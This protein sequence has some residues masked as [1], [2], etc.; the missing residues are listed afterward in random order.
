MA[1]KATTKVPEGMYTVTPQLC[2]NGNCREAIEFYKKA[3]NAELIGNIAES[4]D[5]KSVWHAMIK[6]GN[7]HIMMGDAMPGGYETG[8]KGTSTVGI[9][10]Y[11]EDCDAWFDRAVKAGAEPAMPPMDAFWGDRMGKLKDPF[12][13]SWDIASHDWDYTPEE[14][15]QKQEEFLASMNGA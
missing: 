13:H 2:F 9:W 12:G 7:S 11:V 4:P 10:L 3:F 8:P 1:K 15:Q 6:I 5:G 14:I